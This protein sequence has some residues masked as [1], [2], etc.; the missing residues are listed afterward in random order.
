MLAIGPFDRFI[1]HHA[2]NNKGDC[3]DTGA[4]LGREARLPA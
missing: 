3:G 4:D 1:C 2:H